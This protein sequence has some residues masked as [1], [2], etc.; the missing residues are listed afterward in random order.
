YGE[1]YGEDQVTSAFQTYLDVLDINPPQLKATNEVI[2]K[3][4][5][6]L[7]DERQPT[8]DENSGSEAEHDVVEVRSS[9]EEDADSMEQ[10]TTDQDRESPDEVECSSDEDDMSP[11]IAGTAATSISRRARQSAT[12]DSVRVPSDG[13]RRQQTLTAFMR[14]VNPGSAQADMQQPAAVPRHHSST[15]RP[16][17]A[18]EAAMDLIDLAN[19][20]VF[21]NRHFRPKQRE[22][23]KAALQKRDCFVLMPTGGGKSLCYQVTALVSAD[24]PASFINSQQTRTEVSAV[25]RELNKPLPTC[26]LLY[27]TPEQFVKSTSLQSLLTGLSNRGLLSRL[28]IDEAHCISAWGH[29]FR[30]EYKRLGQVKADICSGLPV[31]ALTATATS[32]VIE[33]IIKSLKIPRCQRFQVS[34]YR[35]NLFL[36]VLPKAKG[37]NEEGNDI[38]LEAMID[39]IWAQPPGASG[40]I[41]CLSRADAENLACHL[42]ERG[43][44]TVGYYHAG[45]TPKQRIQVQREWHSGRLQVVCATI[46]FGMGIDKP[47]V[48]FVMHYT[49]P[50]TCSVLP[51]LLTMSGAWTCLQGYYQEAGRAGRDGLPSECILYYAA[52]DIPRIHQM[53][54]RGSRGRTKQARFQKGMELLDQVIS[55]IYDVRYTSPKIH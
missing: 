39:Y 29:D 15:S 35:S 28:V 25:F 22:I 55:C 24:I 18:R 23:I 36:K 6:F 49:L 31:M 16:A 47:N 20:K 45:M 11:S 53:L 26:K 42:R 14:P 41:Y 10:S 17:T 27:I 12:L 54:R 46:A 51:K 5:D 9:P 52:R 2:G 1:T 43:E 4:L 21:G 34:F 30:P 38:Q 8:D 13:S 7:A 48:R 33:D 44:L 50:K 32:K 40:I 37:K 19:L 3:F